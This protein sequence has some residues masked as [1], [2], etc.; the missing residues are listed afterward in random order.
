MMINKLFI[1][2][3]DP[4]EDLFTDSDI[5]PKIFLNKRDFEE[6]ILLGIFSDDVKRQE[7]FVINISTEKIEYVKLS[8]KN[9]KIVFTY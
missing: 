4:D 9:G 6:C 8:H 2:L 5:K 3:Q 1:V 7:F